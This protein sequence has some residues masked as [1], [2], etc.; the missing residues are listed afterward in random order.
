M[1]WNIRGCYGNK[2]GV[3]IN[4]LQ[5][6]NVVDILSRYDIVFLQ[7][8]HLDHETSQNMSLT[9]FAPGVHYVRQKR[10]KAHKSSGG[11]SV[12]IKE[13]YRSRVKFLPRN[14][15]DIAWLHI[16]HPSNTSKIKSDVY[17]GCVYIPPDNSSFGKSYTHQIWDSLE[18]D[19]E[20]FTSKGQVILCGDFNARTGNCVDFI[21]MD[22]ENNY[23]QLPTDYQ[24][25]KA[26][27]RLSMDEKRV[28][29]SGR[30]LISACIDNNICVLN[31][32]TLGDLEGHYT[33]HSPQGSSVVDYFLCTQQW[34]RYVLGMKVLNLTQYSDHCPMELSVELPIGHTHT[35]TPKN[36][37]RENAFRNKEQKEDRTQTH[38]FLWDEQSSIKI[39]HAFKS[40]SMRDMV[41]ELK[42]TLEV[43]SKK[44]ELQASDINSTV[45]KLNQ[46]FTTTAKMSLK[47]KI[48]NKHGKRKTKKKWFDKDCF[49]HRKEM[50]S[51][52]NA[53]N[54]NPQSKQLRVKYFAQSKQYKKVLR[55]KKKEY[56]RQL[57]HSLSAAIDSDPNSAWQALRELQSYNRE[58]PSQQSH[59]SSNKWFHHLKELIG[60]QCKVSDSR[61]TLV[62]NR[63]AD[64]IN[65]QS[66]INPI[67]DRVITV[68]EVQKAVKNVKCKKSSGLDGIKNEMIKTLL[69]EVK[70]M[71]T[72]VFNLILRSGKYPDEWK[73]G[74]TVPIHKSGCQ[75]N[76]SNYRGITLTSTVGKIF[77]NIINERIM[78]ILEQNNLLAKEQAGFRKGYRTTDQIY[79]L[80]KLVQETLKSRDKRL[81][82]CFVDFS[83]AF[84]NIWH[85]ALLLKIARTGINGKCF[86]V[87]RDMYINA[88]IH[89]QH[90][91]GPSEGIQIRKGVLQGNTLSPTLFNIFINDI[92]E[93]LREHNS[94]MISKSSHQEIP[95]LLYADD[96]AILSTSKI[97]LQEKLNKLHQYCLDWGMEINVG[98][99]KVIIFTKSAPVMPIHF[100][101]GPHTLETVNQYKYLGVLLQANGQFSEATM[102]LSKQ[103]NKAAI[104]LRKAFHGQKYNA[105]IILSLFDS[106]VSPILTYGSEIWFPLSFKYNRDNPK[107]DNVN[108]LLT[109]CVSNKFQHEIVHLQFCRQTLG[110]HKKAMT[111]PSFAELGRFPITFK[112]LQ[113]VIGFW[114]HLMHSKEDSHQKQ[115]YQA[116][117][118]NCEAN[119]WEYFVRETL[120]S[121]GLK[122]VWE[123]QGTFNVCNL[124][125]VIIEKLKSRFIKLWLNQKS[126][127]PKLRFYR[128]VAKEYEMAHYLK[129]NMEQLHKRALSKLR[130]SAHDLQV[131]KGRYLNI[132]REERLCP[133]CKV[134]EDE[135]HFL[136]DC[137]RFNK[138]RTALIARIDSK[139]IGKNEC[140]TNNLLKPS[141]FMLSDQYQSLI[142]QHV[143]TCFS[144]HR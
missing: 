122:H 128:T 12:F 37:H 28:N 53:L 32:R 125:R 79:I 31:G 10:G 113:Q 33:C 60:T 40:D 67:L 101:C 64:C 49:A 24:F 57:V 44:E 8:T 58:T 30:R 16:A 46:M 23:Y 97:G 63:L 124:K 36:R 95:C 20:E 29:K 21:S 80:S 22:S 137:N 68:E 19:C 107:E 18:H 102:H 91:A 1:S 43:N 143:F 126:E 47:Q 15:S 74:I 42:K 41:C 26:T 105:E 34:L 48:K 45:E 7:E 92:V 25:D 55:K 14:N 108:A 133:D 86:Q 72:D 134:L 90:S 106:L 77:C 120:E 51:L 84:D 100:T 112:I 35:C 89:V 138:Q 56:S 62:H 69:P 129:V 104:A 38:N 121:L 116:S 130:I 5:D 94:P 81:Y 75:S 76:P 88:S 52:L 17:L 141:D 111:L 136:D 9:H 6:Q 4:K 13:K 139:E 144:V 110:V 103:G 115:L 61:S 96:L 118:I 135:W 78:Y 127:S 3:K 66:S 132:P 114:V 71:L 142:A 131:E 73:S 54:R 109:A 82:C 87:I 93:I 85:E 65:E 70:D 59:L 11:I 27:E 50:R 98:K 83:K 123:N 117:S 119:S 140:I 39:L 2:D 99:T